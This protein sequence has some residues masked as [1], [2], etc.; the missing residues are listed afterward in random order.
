MLLTELFWFWFSCYVSLYIVWWVFIC[1]DV[2]Q[3]FYPR[4]C[5]HGHCPICGAYLNPCL[6]GQ[7]KDILRVKAS[8]SNTRTSRLWAWSLSA[9]ED[10][11]SELATDRRHVGMVFVLTTTSLLCASCVC[12]CACDCT[13]SWG[14]RMTLIDSGDEYGGGWAKGLLWCVGMNEWRVLSR[15]TMFLWGGALFMRKKSR[16]PYHRAR[17]LLSADAPV[18]GWEI[19][20]TL[21]LERFF[22][23]VA[24]EAK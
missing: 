4:C 15:N 2:W 17:C 20:S 23:T 5:Q 21:D 8:S 6:Q 9:Y 12:T 24:S 22:Q 14:C 19:P 10:F 16:A 11:I 1:I 3:V 13:D 7:G 18:C